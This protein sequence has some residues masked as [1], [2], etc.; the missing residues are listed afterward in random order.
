[1]K[2]ES[3]VTD[4]HGCWVYLDKIVPK[5]EE[6][7]AATGAGAKKPVAPAKG[8][9]AVATEEVKPTFGRAWIDL[10]PFMHPGATSLTQRIFIQQIPP[11]EAGLENAT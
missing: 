10:T 3:N 5:E 6:T 2:F 9:T 4:H 11:Q 1:M 8:K 7:V